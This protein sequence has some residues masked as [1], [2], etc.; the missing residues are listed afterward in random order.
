M[1]HVQFTGSHYEIGLQLGAHLA[2]LGHRIPDRVPFPLTGPRLEFARA[3]LPHCRRWFPAALEELQGLAEGQDCPPDALAAILL[4]MYA[5]PP[6]AL[7]SCFALRNSRG[8]LFG[9]NSD[10]LTALEEQNANHLLRFSDGGLPFLANTTAFVEMEDGINGDG[11]AVGLT[12][13]PPGRPRPGLNAGLQ[14]RLLLESCR[15]VPQALHLLR[16]LPASSCHTLVLADRTGEIALAECHPE[17]VAVRHPRE[18]DAF[19][20][21]TNAF[22]LP[23]LAHLRRSVADDWQAET[24]Y[25]T[26]TRAL[27]GRGSTLDAAGGMD[28]LAGRWGFLCQYDRSQGR[29]TVWSVLWDGGAGRLWRAEGNPGRV[30]FQQDHRPIPAP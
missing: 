28:L 2:R 10:S 4:T 7:C 25:R 6:A 29:D 14:L 30:P 17:G 12:S 9:R 1:L 26:M 27:A 21:A 20:C 22:H 15:T 5:M 23:E 24:R 3:C 19:V 11:L 18:A 16:Q 13:V 8:V